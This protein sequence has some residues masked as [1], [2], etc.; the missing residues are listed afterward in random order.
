MNLISMGTCD[1]VIVSGVELMSDVPIR[2][3]RKMRQLMLKLSRTK[4]WRQRM[5]LISKMAA[6]SLWVPEIL[7]TTE[8]STG[9]E[10][11]LSADRL[12][13]S[14]SISRKEQDEFSANSHRRAQAAIDKGYLSDIMPFNV[15]GTKSCILFYPPNPVRYSLALL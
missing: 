4:T 3:S 6:P 7:D 14:F 12:A 10:F 11:G 5:S 13:A 15:P 1:T 9:E 2:H 8:F